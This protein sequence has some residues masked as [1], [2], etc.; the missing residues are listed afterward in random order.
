MRTMENAPW[1]PSWGSVQSSAA[2]HTV[3]AHSAHAR[4]LVARLSLRSQHT[5]HTARPQSRVTDKI[6]SSIEYP[7]RARGA[8]TAAIRSREE[9]SCIE[10]VRASAR[11]RSR[12]FAG[13][14]AP[15]PGRRAGHATLGLR[16]EY[17]IP[18]LRA[19]T[20][21]RNTASRITKCTLTLVL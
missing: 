9:R 20:R 10:P 6:Q 14:V 5:V 1:Q 17:D 7:P 11:P 3:I 8:D 18:H 19:P 2:E 15:A 4:I 21:P 12:Q 13:V 16:Y